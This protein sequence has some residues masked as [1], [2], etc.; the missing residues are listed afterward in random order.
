MGKGVGLAIALLA[1]AGCKS[2]GDG[3]DNTAGVGGAAGTL[4]GA[5]VSG[6]GAG[7]SGTTAGAGGGAGG[8]MAGAG[9]AGMGG[10]GQFAGCE[11]ADMSAAPSALHAAA[12]AVLTMASPCGFG[13]CHAGVGKAGLVLLNATDLRMTTVG[14]ASCQVPAIPVVDDAGGNAGLANS[15]LWLKLTA[16]ADASGVI[17]GDAAWGAGVNC[18]QMGGQMYGLRMPASNTDTP[19]EEARLAAIRNWICAG[20]PGP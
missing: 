11:V 2:D 12:A 18:G 20:A 1:L 19:L 17:T 14:K 10:G 7:A 5:G 8:A 4:G 13:S 9:A 15:W 6:G 16:P 3:D